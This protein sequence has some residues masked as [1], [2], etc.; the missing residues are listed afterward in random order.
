MNSEYLRDKHSELEAGTMSRISE[1]Q[2]PLHNCRCMD[3]GS[4]VL[5]VL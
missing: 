4:T 5:Y 3:D 1:Y 2:S